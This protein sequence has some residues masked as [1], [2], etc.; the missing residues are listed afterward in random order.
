MI[1]QLELV[2]IFRIILAGVC[3]MIVGLE[4]KN[5]SKEAGIRTHFVV[6]CG[7]AIIM[8]V[9]KY[10]F[11]DVTEIANSVGFEGEIRLDPSRVASTIASG[12]GFLGAGMIFVHKNTITGLTTA[13]GIWATSGIGMAIG[14]GMYFIGVGATFVILLAQLLLH[15]DFHR[16]KNA[17]MKVLSITGVDESDFQ[18]KM[19][20][21]FNEKSVKIHTT[22]V[23]MNDDRTKN[24]IFT[25]ELPKSIT[26]DEIISITGYKSSITPLA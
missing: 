8:I 24:Y 13:A 17:R 5:R 3:G 18:H 15:L 21:I 6:A 7:A 22:S 14:A 16:S 4:R 23:K 26:E 12:I 9:S 11:F 1:N 25:V 20:N 2:Y 10:A 19:I